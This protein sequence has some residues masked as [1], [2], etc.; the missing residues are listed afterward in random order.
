M[1]KYQIT[2]YCICCLLSLLTD[3]SSELNNGI[4]K[5][6]PEFVLAV[7]KYDALGEF[8]EGLAPVGITEN[9]TQLWGYINT[10][11]EEVI[12]CKIEALKVGCFSEGLACIVKD[13]KFSFIDREGKTVFTIDKSGAT[14]SAEEISFEVITK[15][16]LPFFKNG[17]CGL[18]Y[19]DYD[20]VI[21]VDKKGRTIREETINKT[22][23][24][25]II[26]KYE[27]FSEGEGYNNTGLKDRN[28]DIVIPA[29]YNNIFTG[30]EE[31]GVFLATIADNG[32][33]DGMMPE[34]YVGYVDLKGN[35]TFTE[36]QKRQIQRL[37]AAS[38]DALAKAIKEAKWIETEQGFKYPDIMKK[39]NTE[40]EE[41]AYDIDSYSWYNVELCYFGA[42]AW[43]TEEYFFEKG[44][45]A[46]YTKI[47]ETTYTSGDINPPVTYLTQTFLYWSILKFFRK[48]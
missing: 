11:G 10:K 32:G 23:S 12:P 18:C 4:V 25:S 41:Y 36:Q 15:S 37:K 44:I 38:P 5:I 20:K 34:Y 26:G 48:K 21:Y 9:A 2:I 19:T 8:S 43:A 42:G 31:S 35:D 33:E 6:T 17:E 22:V 39:S 29:K 47:R 24:E 28:G 16:D 1:K 30:V 46:P 13:E 45:I 3:C 40:I 14:C 7:Q 27:A